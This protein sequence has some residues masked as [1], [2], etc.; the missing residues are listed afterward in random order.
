MTLGLLIAV[1]AVALAQDTGDPTGAPSPAPPAPTIQSDKEDYPPSDT[2]IL[3]GSGWQPG[4]TV[5]INVNDDEGQTWNRNVD[6]IADENGN[7]RDEF[8]LPDWFVANY[9]V[10]A[11][12][13]SGT[14]AIS[15]FTDAVPVPARGCVGSPIGAAQIVVNTTADQFDDPSATNTQCSLRE[16]ISAANADTIADTI[17]L[18]SGDYTLTRTGSGED[19]NETGDLD[20]LR[21][22]RIIGGGARTTN[23][24]AGTNNTNGI[25]RVLHVLASGN[26]S[27]LNGAT[28]RYGQINDDGGGIKSDTAVNPLTLADVAITDNHARNGGGISASSSIS[29]NR[30]T[31]SGNT[32]SL[33]GGGLHST[34]TGQLTNVTITGNTAAS[35]GGGLLTKNENYTLINATVSHN[36]APNGSNITKVPSIG[37]VTLFNTIV[38]DGSP[39]ANCSGTILNGSPLISPNANNLESA[40]NTCGFGSERGSKSGPS[41]NADL[42]ALQNNGGLTDTRAL[43][44]QSAAIDAATDPSPAPEIDQ[45]GE[46]RP[47][48]G[49][50]NGTALDDIGA[51]EL[52]APLN[53]APVANDDA[54]T[55]NED[56]SVAIDVKA[57]DTDANG[58]S[59]SVVAT[60]LSDPANGAVALITSGADTGKV[61]Y[62][63]DLNYNNTGGPNADTFTYKVSDSTAQSNAA[64]VRV[65]V[66]PVN[67]DPTI[68]DIANQETNEDVSTGAISFTVGDL[69]TA[70][71]SLEVEGSSTNQT[72]VPNNDIVF[73]GSGADR[74]VT[75]TPAA[76]EFGTATITVTV[77]D[78]NG[79]TVSDTFTLTVNPV[80]DPP[81]AN[82][83]EY[84]TDEDTQL[85]VAA[86]GVLGNDSDVEGSTLSA[87]LGT[88]P[89]DGTLDLKADGSFT[90]EPDPNF[91]GSD[92]FTYRASDGSANSDLATVDITVNPVNDA[93]TTPGAITSTQSLTND[94]TF[95]LDWEASTDVEGD[96]VTYTLEKRDSDD[97]NWSEVAS[98]LTSASYTFGD[99]NSVENEGTWDYR[100]KAVD[101]PA[102]SDYST[103]ENLVKVDKSGPNAPTLSFNT[104]ANQSFKA[105][106]SGVDWYKDSA[107]IDVAANG[108]KPLA[109]TSDGSGVDAASLLP[110]PFSVSTN[111]TSTASRK[112]KD[113]ANNESDAGTLQVKVDAADPTLGSCPTAEPFILNSGGGTQSVGPIDASDGESGVD[114]AA[115]TLSGSVNTSTVGEKSVTFKAVDHVGHEVTKECKYNVNYAFSGF[116]QPINH[117]TGTDVSTFKAG[118]T[119]PVKIVLKDANDNVVQS[120]SAPQWLTPQKGSVTNQAIDQIVFTDPATS[121]NLYK[122]DGTQYHYNWST[123]GVDGGFYY[124][125]GVKLDDGQTYYGNIS[126][127]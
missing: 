99:T 84:N 26:L 67:D 115:S 49:D 74:T 19:N 10:T 46:R 104:S 117:Q 51:Y 52:Q 114:D 3:T 39:G 88:G 93:P 32:A 57:N 78:A 27:P 6:V 2:V 41:V 112:V 13:S 122:W 97:A 8:V 107:L 9:S 30:A 65:T 55:I 18:P 68:S 101:S 69:E 34:R 125:I 42:G 21:P 98:G 82:G 120:A 40:T 73:G 36:S 83:D 75:I 80:N 47:K 121:G 16:A 44:A 89:S 102:E 123:K 17:N 118:S 105:T 62:T 23:I 38:S 127:R 5:N 58:N 31:I 96:D 116:L 109:D 60:S 4:E 59:L 64:T 100:V 90:Y 87:D 50:G 72:L 76:D 28:V 70:A 29:I 86:P 79:G 110:N 91:N 71:S 56:A 20:V 85:Q 54:A 77:T 35:L 61:L 45:R 124:K 11:T 24:Q 12:G 94:G 15:T 14:T 25:D 92:S 126:L 7:V 113:N 43:G 48:D 37:A 63:P 103:A 53:A 108:D 81:V 111:G 1:P 106:V 66:N 22:L 95:T 33:D 119:I